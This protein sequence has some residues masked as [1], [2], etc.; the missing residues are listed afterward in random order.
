M[1]LCRIRLFVLVASLA[2]LAGCSSSTDSGDTTTDTGMTVDTGTTTDTGMTNDTGTPDSGGDQSFS[3][4]ST[5]LTDGEPIPSLYSCEGSNISPPLAWVGGPADTETFVLIVS[6]LDIPVS[7][8][9]EPDTDRIE[10]SH[11]IV[12]DIPESVLS[13][14]RDL[15]ESSLPDGA[16]EF[17]PWFGPCP[18]PGDIVHR[19]VFTIYA[20]DTT[21]GTPPGELITI[22]EGE[23]PIDAMK[24]LIEGHILIQ[25]QLTG[26]YEIDE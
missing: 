18:P 6:D 23:D 3:V 21:F 12:Y 16:Y 1:A 26:T 20:L 17:A 9:P 19:Y 25:A 15:S 22:G 11:W 7:F 24:A 13:L 5:A 10:G 2:L 8:P 14:S 4:N